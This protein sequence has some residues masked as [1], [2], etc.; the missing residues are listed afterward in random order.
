MQKKFSVTLSHINRITSHMAELSKSIIQDASLL[1]EIVEEVTGVTQSQIQSKVRTRHIAEARMMMCESLRRNSK[2]RLNEVALA[3]SGL[4]HSTLV[5]YKTKVVDLC[6]HDYK[7][8]KEFFTISARF[9]QIKDG[10][11]PLKKKLEFAVR[12]RDNLNREIRRIKK[13]LKI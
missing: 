9:K 4:N 12:D 11:L 13:L 1:F 3:V 5:Y 7:F 2:Y 8:K 10:G 6:E